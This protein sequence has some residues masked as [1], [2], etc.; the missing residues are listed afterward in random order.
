MPNSSFIRIAK[1][2]IM[3]DLQ[4]DNDIVEALG[5]HDDEDAENLVYTRLFPHYFIPET[6]ETV[7][8]YVMVEIDI[9]QQRRSYGNTGS[10]LVYPTITFTVLSHQKNMKLDMAGVSAV[11]TDYIAEL[12]DLKYNG[13][14]GFGL[15]ELEVVSNTAGSLNDTYRFRQIVFRAAD[16]N[17]SY[18]EG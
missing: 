11:R 10:N 9:T 18:C 4:K 2:R 13:R 12:L 15:K 5:L 7:K 3:V 6:Q 14:D 17:D 1:N 8:T 16:F